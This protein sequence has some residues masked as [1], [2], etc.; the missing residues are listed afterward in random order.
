MINSL[1]DAL[2]VIFYD[3]IFVIYVTSG[4]LRCW[5]LQVKEELTVIIEIKSRVDVM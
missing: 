1:F 2:T 5:I 3:I 4:I